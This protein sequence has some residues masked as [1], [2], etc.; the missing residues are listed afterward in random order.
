MQRTQ[1]LDAAGHPLNFIATRETLARDV[2]PVH[3][4]LRDGVVLREFL[5]AIPPRAERF[6]VGDAA[7]LNHPL[8]VLQVPPDIRMPEREERT[9]HEDDNDDGSRDDMNRAKIEW[10]ERGIRIAEINAGAD[11][12]RRGFRRRRWG[13]LG[14]FSRRH[15]RNSSGSAQA[16]S[17]L[18]K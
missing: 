1:H 3:D 11:A 9:E 5:S 8:A 14:R 17:T 6:T 4:G 16:Q 7:V 2:R 18:S 10:R 15:I 13:L 12:H